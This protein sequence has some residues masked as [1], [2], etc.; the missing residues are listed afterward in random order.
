MRPVKWIVILGFSLVGGV[1]IHQFLMGNPEF[2]RLKFYYW[3]THEV[4]LGTL[5]F[6]SFVMGFCVSAMILSTSLIFKVLE[7]RRLSRENKAFES[8]LATKAPFSENG[9]K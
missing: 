1:L 5:V 3:R 4:A 7:V 9:T 6:C 2:V 8:L